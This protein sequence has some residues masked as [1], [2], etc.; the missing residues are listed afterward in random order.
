MT[1]SQDGGSV[2]AIRPVNPNNKASQGIAGWAG[3]VSGCCCTS[4]DKLRLELQDA[5][6]LSWYEGGDAKYLAA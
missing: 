6:S 2:L 5:H 4:T 3:G 1:P